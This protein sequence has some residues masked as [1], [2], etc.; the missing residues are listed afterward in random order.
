MCWLFSK[1]IPHDDDDNDD[2]VC[3][4]VFTSQSRFVSFIQLFW[5]EVSLIKLI[6][7]HMLYVVFYFYILTMS[8]E[9][10]WS[11]EHM[12]FIPTS[13]KKMFISFKLVCHH[14]VDLLVQIHTFHLFLF[15]VF[16]SSFFF[17]RHFSFEKYRN[18]KQTNKKWQ[19]IHRRSLIR[20]K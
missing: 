10:F 18:A 6:L 12:N 17:Q 2:N 3:K 19:R 8:I 15:R 9:S 16:D 5:V 7:H 14:F 20:T 1:Q 4:Y 13:W 11:P